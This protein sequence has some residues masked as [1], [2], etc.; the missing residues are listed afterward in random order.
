MSHISELRCRPAPSGRL[1]HAGVGAP[2]TR[3]VAVGEHCPD[4]RLTRYQRPVA[5]CHTSATLDRAVPPFDARQIIR[6]IAASKL[7]RRNPSR[8]WVF[9]GLHGRKGTGR[10]H[11]QA[12]R[13]HFEMHGG[14]LAFA[15]TRAHAITRREIERLDLS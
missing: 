11:R 12:A 13:V 15:I 1:C 3:D 4:I 10:R 7:K 2:V 9:N 14:V 6:N 8:A 5:V